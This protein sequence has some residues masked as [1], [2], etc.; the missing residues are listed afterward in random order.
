ME[1]ISSKENKRIKT[2]KKLLSSASFRREEGVFVAEGLRLCGDAIKSGAEI[3]SAFFSESFY[4]KN[5]SFVQEAS[6][7]AR[8][9]GLHALYDI[10]T[11]SGEDVT[12]SN[13]QYFF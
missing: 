13:R 12:L 5:E 2:I 7:I 6:S 4:N 1:Q 8:R 9:A 11:S 3:T 10:F